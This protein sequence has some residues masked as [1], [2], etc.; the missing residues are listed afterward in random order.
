M[1]NREPITF[2]GR[3][4]KNKTKAE[5]PPTQKPQPAI[6]NTFKA[7][8]R[9]KKLKS[10]YCKRASQHIFV[11]VGLAHVSDKNKAH[12]RPL[13]NLND[14]GRGWAEPCLGK[15]VCVREIVNTSGRTTEAAGTFGAAIMW[16]ES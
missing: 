1:R 8:K 10:A 14:V 3:K 16:R 9:E 2:S 6:T 12:P 4:L 7:I 11:V 5:D 13:R 15:G